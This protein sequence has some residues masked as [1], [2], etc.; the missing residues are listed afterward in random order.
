MDFVRTVF[1]HLPE[2]AGSSV[3]RLVYAIGGLAILVLVYRWYRL[4]NEMASNY[5]SQVETPSG[6]DD[7]VNGTSSVPTVRP[8]TSFAAGIGWR[9]L[10]AQVGSICLICIA[11]VLAIA[12]NR[13]VN[14]R[15]QADFIVTCLEGQT[16]RVGPFSVE[17]IR[18]EKAE[19]PVVALK[20][21]SP[22]E[23]LIALSLEQGESVRL[24]K[25]WQL[26]VERIGIASA[27]LR[28]RRLR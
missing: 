27:R 26:Q 13:A 24:E 8:S 2:A 3:A 14:A 4:R 19:R 6:D 1:Y 16:C 17:L 23:A 21:S 25:D 28:F 10:A 18:V 15:S 5:G 11:L 22:G 20:I 9:V 12:I 7:L